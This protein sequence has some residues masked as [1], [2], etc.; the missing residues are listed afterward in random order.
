MPLASWRRLGDAETSA[1]AGAATASSERRTIA[2]RR[3]ARTGTSLT[4]GL[5]AVPRFEHSEPGK[6]SQ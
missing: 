5:Y 2:T 1:L 4:P 3:G 6:V